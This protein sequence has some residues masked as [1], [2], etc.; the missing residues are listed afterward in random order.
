MILTA[1]QPCYLPWCGLFAK[2]QQADTFVLL[3]TVQYQPRDF[4]NRNKI[5]TA[6]GPL[7]LTVPVYTKGHRDKPFHQIQINNTLPWQRKHWKSIEQSYRKAA[8]WDDYA[9]D[10]RLFYSYQYD[11]LVTVNSAMLRWFLEVLKI[12]VTYLKASDYQFKGHKA[13]LV[14]DMC[15]QLGAREYIFGSKGRDYVTAADNLAFEKAGI[16]IQFQAYVHPEYMQFGGSFIPNL[17]V[18]DLLLHHGPAAKSILMGQPC[19]AL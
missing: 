2:I 13:T 3:D 19:Q 17:S 11:D 7:W 6:R 12:D 8:Y 4:N 16:K 18:I 9:N 5:W 10:L 15:Q 1:Q 14:L